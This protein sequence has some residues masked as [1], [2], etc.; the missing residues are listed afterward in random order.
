M[1]R[2]PRKTDRSTRKIVAFLVSVVLIAASCSRGPRAI[3]STRFRPKAVCAEAFELYDANGDEVLS[4]NELDASPGLKYAAKRNDTSGD[5]SL[6]RNEITIMVDG[7]NQKAIGLLTLRCT[8]KYKRRPLQGAI[9]R[10]EPEP[11]LQGVIESAH[12]ITD[13]FGDALL[14]VPKEKRPIPDA[15]PGVQLGLYRV[16]ISKM[17]SGEE[18]IP[19]KYNQQTELGQEVSFDDPG[20]LN[21]IE[22]ELKR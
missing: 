3:P 5:G 10:L 21:G 8:V 11:F 4:T 15:P 7:W 20:V 16:V 6:D 19:A 13:E 12:G 18:T 9:V 14:T 22:Y 1:Q 2:L 17:H